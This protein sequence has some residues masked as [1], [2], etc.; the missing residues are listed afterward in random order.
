M[1]DLMA[2]LQS[3]RKS[4]NTVLMG[5]CTLSSTMTCSAHGQNSMIQSHV[6]AYTMGCV[7]AKAARIT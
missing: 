7:L 5:T 1:P 3:Q 4:I 2:S 6:S